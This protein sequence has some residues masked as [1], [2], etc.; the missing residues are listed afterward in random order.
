MS[1]KPVWIKKSYFQDLKLKKEKSVRISVVCSMLRYIASS[2]INNKPLTYTKYDSSIIV[3]KWKIELAELCADSERIF[4]SY[5]QFCFLC[6][7]SRWRF[8][9]FHKDREITKNL[10]TLADSNFGEKKTFL[11]SLELWRNFICGNET[12]SPGRAVSLHLARSGSQ[13]EHRIRWILP[14]R[15]ACHIIITSY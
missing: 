1:K 8:F 13:S 14:A 11:H 10:F 3:E 7:H 9:W 12:G 6:F 5:Q 2:K 4:K 15:G